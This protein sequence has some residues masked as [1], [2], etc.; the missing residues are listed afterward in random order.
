MPDLGE[1]IT[2]SA[3]EFLRDKEKNGDLVSSTGQTGLVAP[4]T[5]TSIVPALGKTFFIA[6]S[7]HI[8]TGAAIVLAES[9]LQNDGTDKDIK[10]SALTADLTRFFEGTII[11]DSM[12]GDG[13]RIY[14]IQKTVGA[15]NNVMSGTILGWIENT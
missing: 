9:V 12:V 10:R 11:G 4:V 6:K 13:V 1:I 14:R 7:S 8:H 3:L 15:V 5:V 2:L